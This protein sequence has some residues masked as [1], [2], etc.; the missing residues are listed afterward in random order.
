MEIA[1][2]RSIDDLTSGITSVLRI[3]RVAVLL[4]S[5]V[6]WIVALIATPAF[7]EPADLL[8][9]GGTVVTMEPGSEPIVDGAVAIVGNKIAAVGP[10]AEL[11]DKYQ[12]VTVLDAGGKVVMPGLVNTHG[13][14]PMTLFR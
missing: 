1:L 13:H 5:R 8:I 7:A 14:V 10:A 2:I 3:H 11:R 12:A 4:A 6:F 9:T